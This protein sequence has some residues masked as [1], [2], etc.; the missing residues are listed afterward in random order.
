MTKYLHAVAQ[1]IARWWD[2]FKS[3]LL[4]PMHNDGLRA[5]GDPVH[6]VRG[7]RGR[8]GVARVPGHRER[9]R[10]EAGQKATANV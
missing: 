7:P 2:W 6:G 5:T 4:P 10:R 8:A 1:T 9:G 3:F